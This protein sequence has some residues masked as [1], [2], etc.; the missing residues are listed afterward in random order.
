MEDAFEKADTGRTGLGVRELRGALRELGIEATAQETIKM[1]QQYNAT[2]SGKLVKDEFASLIG[3]MDAFEQQEA[4]AAAA[5]APSDEPPA[6]DFDKPEVPAPRGPRDPP[7]VPPAVSTLSAPEPPGPPPVPKGFKYVTNLGVGYGQLLKPLSHRGRVDS[8]PRTDSGRH[9]WTASD[10]G[11]RGGADARGSGRGPSPG[12]ACGPLPFITAEPGMGYERIGRDGYD[13]AGERDLGFGGERA[14]LGG[15]ERTRSASPTGGADAALAVEVFGGPGEFGGGGGGV[16][17]ADERKG[18]LQLDQT[19][20][21]V[22]GL[23]AEY[24]G[25]KTLHPSQQWIVRA[26]RALEL[27]YQAAGRAEAVQ[28]FNLEVHS[29]QLAH[30]LNAHRDALSMAQAARRQAEGDAAR[31]MEAVSQEQEASAALREHNAALE[32][33][34]DMLA[35]E[36]ERARSEHKAMHRE[37]QALQRRWEQATHEAQSWS[38]RAAEAQEQSRHALSDANVARDAAQ[39]MQRSMLTAQEYR[40]AE[41]AGYQLQTIIQLAP[42]KPILTSV[43]GQPQHVDAFVPI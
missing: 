3:A 42:S 43:Y 20:E 16:F 38:Q 27:R 18:E 1:H 11:G 24:A 7:L 25:G 21:G 9:R 31:A 29:Q 13:V 41:E 15:G 2:G 12:S 36:L 37:S 8:K 33:E 10:G 17:G 6:E 5:A 34:R 28:R 35:A 32:R 30:E 26:M 22:L 19:E 40:L 39:A 4:D 23:L 14:V